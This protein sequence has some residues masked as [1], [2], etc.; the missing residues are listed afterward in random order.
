MKATKTPKSSGSGPINII[1]D[2]VVTP[3]TSDTGTPANTVPIPVTVV[4]PD[5]TPSASEATLLEVRDN[6]AATVDE[7]VDISKEATQLEVLTEVQGINVASQEIAGKTPALGQ[8]TMALSV[9]VVIASNQSSLPVTVGNFPAATGLTDAELRATAVPVSVSNFPATQPVSGSVAV[10]NFPATQPI[11]AASLPLPTGAATEAT[12]AAQSAKLPATLGQKTMAA[13]F[14]VTI[15]SDQPGLPAASVPTAL[16][17]KQAAVS[18]STTAVRL[19]TDAAAP[20]A[21]RRKLQ[22]IIEPPSGDVNYFM[23][24]NTVTASGGTRGLRL[25]PGTLYTYDNDANDYYI[26]ADTAAQT[27]FVMEIE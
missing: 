21:T 9:P 24:S 1:Q 17:V 6:T 20:S 18:F 4:N 26:I 14:A 11:S 15:A 13:S 12:L 23:G 27:V 8:A 7:L 16:T 2:G 5:G 22:F 19:T 25:Y 10:S 3:V